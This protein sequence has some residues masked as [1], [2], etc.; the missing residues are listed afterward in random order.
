[1]REVDHSPASSTEVKNRWSCT[2]APLICLHSVD[3]NNLLLTVSG[4]RIGRCRPLL[5][6][7]YICSCRQYLEAVSS[8][9]KL[10]DAQRRNYRDLLKMEECVIQMFNAVQIS[11]VTLS[12]Q[13]V[14]YDLFPCA[15][16][17]NYIMN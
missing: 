6:I 15:A 11:A 10:D 17:M 3:R 4:S 8:T 13:H 1:M 9:C 12:L 16:L 14:V 7:L 5:G 2:S